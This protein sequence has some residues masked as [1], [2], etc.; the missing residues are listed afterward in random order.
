MLSVHVGRSKAPRDTV[1]CPG[2]QSTWLVTS[3][4]EIVPLFMC[5]VEYAH[6]FR[7]P[8]EELYQLK[9]GVL[10]QYTKACPTCVSLFNV[11]A[12]AGV[13]L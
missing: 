11:H 12:K 10:V 4:E 8:S 7:F 9:L 6:I 1:R 13:G 5:E 3:S 2:D